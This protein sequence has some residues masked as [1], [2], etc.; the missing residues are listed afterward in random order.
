MPFTSR[1]LWLQGE[2]NRGNVDINTWMLGLC[3]LLR[4]D[5][6]RRRRLDL[7]QL[8]KLAIQY[9]AAGTQSLLWHP[10][11]CEKFPEVDTKWRIRAAVD[12]GSQKLFTQSLRTELP[13]SSETFVEIGKGL[14]HFKLD[15]E[16][17]WPR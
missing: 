5:A 11:H 2:V 7:Y 4:D 3:R 9:Q 8:S 14:W 6:S 16:D 17:F 1:R 10:Y 13:I 15:T 12:L